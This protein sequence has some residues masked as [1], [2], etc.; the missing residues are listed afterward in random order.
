VDFLL[1]LVAVGATFV[2][3]AATALMLLT[4]R[5]ARRVT[6]ASLLVPVG[7]SVAVLMLSAALLG[8]TPSA[9]WFLVDLVLGA[10]LGALWA[11]T[12]RLFRAQ[13]GGVRA[14]APTSGTWPS[15]PPSSP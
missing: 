8:A 1:R 2:L 11:R 4:F 5:R 10:G 13:D 3:V 14:A 6:T 7:T 9:G 12:H 15:G